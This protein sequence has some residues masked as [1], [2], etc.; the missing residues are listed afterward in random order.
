[1]DDLKNASFWAINSKKFDRPAARRKPYLAGEKF[2][3]QKFFFFVATRSCLKS[4]SVLKVFLKI[5][6]KLTFS[7]E[8]KEAITI[9]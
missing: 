6:L 7:L 2:E 3:S 1:M 9:R 4:E 8:M 5:D